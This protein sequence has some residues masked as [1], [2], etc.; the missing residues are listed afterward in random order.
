MTS[1]FD[2]FGWFYDKHWATA[3]A[4]W[5]IPAIDRLLMP[6]VRAGGPLLDVCCGTGTLARSLVNRGYQLTGVDSSEGMLQLA[7]Q[8]VPEATFLHADASQFTLAQPVD[9]AMSVFD[10]LNNILEPPA[11]Q[12]AFH[13]VH[14]AL[15]AGGYFVFDVNTSAAYG[16]RWDQSYS[17]VYVDH[18]FFMRGGFDPHS[19]I[20]VTKVTMFRLTNGWVRSDVELLQRPWD[21]LDVEPLLEKAGFTDICSWRAIEDLGMPGHYGI[22]R[23]YF[24][25]R[26]AHRPS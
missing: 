4:Q 1:Q 18:A 8:N 11:L 21:P 25:A 13:C 12:A 20:G 23:V 7:R 14:D 5:Q 16:E 10:S 6:H 9:G 24:R 22:G 26:T 3:F 2:D 17:E 15:R 19:R